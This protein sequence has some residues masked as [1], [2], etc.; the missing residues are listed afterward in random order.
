MESGGKKKGKLEKE[1]KKREKVYVV[2]GNR[3]WGSEGAQ[4]LSCRLTTPEL[5]RLGQR[6]T[7]VELGH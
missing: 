6:G 3:D 4:L 7:L 1:R 2:V 5:L